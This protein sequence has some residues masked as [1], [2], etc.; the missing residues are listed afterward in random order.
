MH[1]PDKVWVQEVGT[2]TNQAITRSVVPNR[3]KQNIGDENKYDREGY[4]IKML[5]KESLA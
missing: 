5:L 1:V 3:K 2:Q 4:P